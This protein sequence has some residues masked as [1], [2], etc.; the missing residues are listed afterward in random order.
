MTYP[1]LIPYIAAPVTVWSFLLQVGET[2]WLNWGAGVAMAVLCL[3]F[4]RQDRRH[5]E[6]QLAALSRELFELIKES[7]EN[8]GKMLAAIDK[9][10]RSRMC[11][12][13]ADE[14]AEEVIL[15]RKKEL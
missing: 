15:R 12:Y 9:L 6:R 8:R 11:V 10:S 3:T 5:S 4:Y 2:E 1:S 7:N 13:E 14:S